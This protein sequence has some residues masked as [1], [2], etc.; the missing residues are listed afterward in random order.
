MLLRILDSERERG[1]TDRVVAGGLAGFVDNLVAEDADGVLSPDVKALSEYDRMEVSDRADAVRRVLSKLAASGDAVDSLPGAKSSKSSG[2]G[3][4]TPVTSLFRVGP[5]YQKMLEKLGIQTY[6]DVLFHFPRKYLDRSTFTPVA[7]AK[8]GLSVNV[9][10][11]V[12]EVAGRKSPRGRFVLTEALLG[13]DSG[14]IRAIWFNQPYVAKNIRNKKGVAFFGRVSWGDHGP[15]LRAP[16][17]ELDLGRSLHSGRQVPI[18]PS[19]GKLSQKLLRLWASQVVDVSSGLV[20]EHLP[21]RILESADLI[22][23]ADA[24]RSIHFPDAPDD[25]AGAV[26]RLAFDEVFLLQL[27]VLLR[28]R[29]WREGSPGKA[30][31]VRREEVR[32]FVRSLEF[33]LTGDQKRAVADVLDD[34]EAD[35]AMSRLLQGDVGSGKT[36]VA[37]CASLAAA[38]DGS[39]VAFMAPTQILA[40]QHHRTLDDLL[41]PWG[42][43]VELITGAVSKAQRRKLW[44]RAAEGEIDVL[45]GTQALI[46]DEAAFGNLNLVV[47]DEQH[48]FGVHQRARLRGMAFNPHMLVMTATPIPRTLA[49]TLYGDLDVTR[50]GELPPGRVP[51]KTALIAPEK[52]D[53]A[54]AFVRE[55]I[56]EGRQVFVVFPIIEESESLQVR[57]AE[58]EYERLKIDVFPSFAGEIGLLHGRMSNKKKTETMMRFRAGELKVLVTTAVVE[59]GVDVPNAAVM[60]V[61]GAERFGLAQLHQLRGRVG[62]SADQG[63]CLLLSDST[64]A[65]ENERLLAL[66]RTTDGFAL[67]EKDLELRGPGEILGS[68]QSGLPALKVA[69]LSDVPTLELARREAVA[70][71]KRDGNL[72]EPENEGIAE[73]LASFWD[74]LAELS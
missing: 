36:I 40:E 62:R 24:L 72:S 39:Q 57:A 2:S 68:R 66:T 3:L 38:R 18:Y 15:E 34:I 33:R 53:R 8:S 5:Q 63:Y 16:E 7:E 70:L 9:I 46:T 58:A 30:I 61:E 26:R 37:A 29:E 28:R 11:D 35:V 73:R 71:F 17:Y 48:R 44:K 50:I 1:F 6:R 42:L 27:G 25:A 19:T 51:V 55:K 22:P 67:A 12:L 43:N 69:S 49:L 65:A 56:A 32:E 23:I 47:V 10:A 59:V 45:V 41:S 21:K 31:A 52:R 60:L 64:D 14:S 20:P 54:Y 74:N 4:D 13:D